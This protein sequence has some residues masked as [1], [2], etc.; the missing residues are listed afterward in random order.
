MVKKIVWRSTAESFKFGISELFQSYKAWLKPN[1]FAYSN[2]F[3]GVKLYGLFSILG[4]GVCSYCQ[5]G[6][7]FL[8]YPPLARSWKKVIL[9]RI[10][11]YPNEHKA[12]I[13]AFNPKGFV[14]TPRGRLFLI[15]TTFLGTILRRTIVKRLFM[16]GRTRCQ[17]LI[18]LS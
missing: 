18:F 9:Q 6:H 11:A 10:R 3:F 12:N 2:N 5:R 1:Y 16:T 15:L 7:S 13:S 14:R 4:Y 8:P 17:N